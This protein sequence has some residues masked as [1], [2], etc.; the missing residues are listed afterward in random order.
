MAP[1]VLIVRVPPAANSM[2]TLQMTSLGLTMSDV[3]QVY[4]FIPVASMLAPIVIGETR[5]LIAIRRFSVLLLL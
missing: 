3:A 4:L 2:L 1:I 5:P